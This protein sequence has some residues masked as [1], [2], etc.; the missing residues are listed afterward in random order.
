MVGVR[1]SIIERRNFPYAA[2]RDHKHTR[3]NTR[4]RNSHTPHLEPPHPVRNPSLTRPS[5]KNAKTRAPPPATP[6]P[7]PASSTS[8]GSIAWASRPCSGAGARTDNVPI[9]TAALSRTPAAVFVCQH[10]HSTA[11]LRQTQYPHPR[12]RK[13]FLPAP[14]GPDCT[15]SAE[16]GRRRTAPPPPRLGVRRAGPA[17]PPAGAARPCRRRRPG[18]R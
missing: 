13:I 1:S 11:N 7:A 17:S 16:G 9:M 8:T 15:V 5:S 12:T 2:S 14:G 6:G 4:R 3:R 18:R 10:T